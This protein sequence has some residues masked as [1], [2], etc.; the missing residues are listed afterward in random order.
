MHFPSTDALKAMLDSSSLE[1]PESLET[2][3]RKA[4]HF[5]SSPLF[6]F[7]LYIVSEQRYEVFTIISY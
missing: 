4:Y 1:F 2:C 6:R 3:F 7:N 5:E